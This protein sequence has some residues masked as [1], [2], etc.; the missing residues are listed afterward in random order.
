MAPSPGARNMAIDVALLE[1]VQGGAPPVLRL[2]RWDPPC[3]SLGRNQPA[4]GVYDEQRIR[5]AGVELVRRPTGGLAVLHDRELTYAVAVGLRVLGGARAS[6]AMINRAIVAGLR[7]LGV[8]ATTALAAPVATAPLR[9][10]TPQ[11][12]CFQRPAAGEV[13]AAGRK[14]V[15]SAQRAERRTLLQHGSI[16]LEGSQ[17]RVREFLCAPAPSVADGSITLADLLPQL[18]S[19]GTVVVALLAGFREV[20]GSDLIPDTL[21]ASERERAHELAVR[22]RSA[23]W[24]WRR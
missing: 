23:E 7:S 9:A 19:P 17:E 11:D 4:R 1:A 20:V 8:P 3:L 14:L 24:T 2:Y 15:G 22:F 16:L 10:G 12:P 5:A 6:Y 13:L 21:S 18:P